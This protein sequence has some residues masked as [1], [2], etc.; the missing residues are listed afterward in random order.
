[1]S[2]HTIIKAL[3]YAGLIPFVTAAIAVAS[4]IGDP[5]LVMLMIETYAFGI[6]CFLT[7][8]WWGMC[9]DSGNRT[10]VILSNGY[11]LVAFAMLLLAQPW[12]PLAA[13]ILLIGIFG[14]ETNKVLFPSLSVDYRRLRAILTLVSSISM[15]T[16]HFAS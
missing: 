14:L 11:F 6:I 16:I 10:V 15:L 7:G 8:S 1:M 5:D 2:N 3:G 13:S 9:A 12:W 4:G